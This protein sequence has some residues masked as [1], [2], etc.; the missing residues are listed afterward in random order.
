MNLRSKTNPAADGFKLPAEWDKHASCWLAWPSHQELWLE[1]LPFVQRE[2]VALCEGICDLDPVT[3]N[4][5]G[6]KL[7]ILVPTAQARAQ[8][9]EA[10]NHLPVTFYDIPFGD[11][12]LRDTAPVFIKSAAEVASVRFK[13]NSWGGKYDLPHDPQVAEKIAG[14]SSLAS[15]GESW[16]LEGGSIEVDGEGT[17]LT[18]K[19]C[20]L[21]KNRNRAM[22]QEQIEKSLREAFGVTKILWITEGLINDHTDGHIDTLVRFCGPGEVLCMTADSSQDPNKDILAKIQREL[23]GMTDAKGRRLKVHLVPSPGLVVSDDD[24]IMPASYVNFYIGNSTVLVPT[25]GSP[26]DERAVKAIAALF[27]NRKTLGLS[28]KALL[29]GGGAFHCITQQVPL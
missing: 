5:R 20:L 28:A 8:A 1:S 4:P 18:T 15:Y 17:C 24:Q 29:S 12:W 9:S 26:N 13:F 3:K 25:Y 19:Q 21:N 11:I 23:D 27:P 10:L 14:A 16:I 6:E 22:S 2:F 7:N